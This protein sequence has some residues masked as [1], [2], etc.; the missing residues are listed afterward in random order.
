MV[1][2]YNYIYKTLSYLHGDLFSCSAIEQGLRHSEVVRP[3]VTVY[4]SI[5]I[6]V[7]IHLGASLT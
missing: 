3:Y 1:H 2:V 6:C 5:Y 7:A 4:T